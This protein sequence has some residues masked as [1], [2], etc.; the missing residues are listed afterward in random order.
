[1]RTSEIVYLSILAVY[2]CS[3][4]SSHLKDVLIRAEN[5]M[6]N[7]PDSALALLQSV[8]N[9]DKLSMADFAAYQLAYT[10]AKDKCY[11]DLA[12]DTANILKSLTYYSRC[13]D[14]KEKGW[15]NYYAGR[16]YQDAGRS[17]ESGLYFLK[18]AECGMNI[19]DYLLGMMAN[20]CLGELHGGQYAFDKALDSFK[21]AHRI[22][23]NVS[24]RRYESSLLN[25]IG[26]EYGI[27]DQLDSAFHYLYKAQEVACKQKDTLSMAAI[28]ND[29]AVYLRVDSQYQEAKFFLNQ[30]VLL[31]KDSNVMTIQKISMAEIYA[32]L[33]ESDSAYILLEEVKKEVEE[34]D[35][36]ELLAIYYYSLSKASFFDKNYELAFHYQEKYITC[37]DS[38]YQLQ[39]KNSL[40]E[41]EQMYNYVR[42]RDVNTS[43]RFEQRNTYVIL[44]ILLLI[45]F[46]V[47]LVAGWM[48]KRKKAALS[49][50]EEMIETLRRMQK[51]S[52][53]DQ[54][55]NTSTEK[56]IT[57]DS[58]DEAKEQ[59]IKRALLMQLNI[60]KVLAKLDEGSDKD[61]NFL[62]RFN[63]LF[64]GEQHIAQVDWDELYQLI[65]LLFDAFASKLQTHYASVLS[66]KEIQ[67]C[68]L[69][70][71][72][73]DTTEIACVMG[74]SINTVRTR[75]TTIRKK[76]SAP[77][78]C[79]I[80]DFLDISG[81]S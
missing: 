52:Q 56:P 12:A 70:R 73:M 78:A 32:Y 81:N 69:L 66:E 57:S 53:S 41:I 64:Y 79:N 22:Y 60:V 43:L 74:Q 38:V 46:L 35:D 76:L 67:L 27:M 55:N 20:Y 40:A 29:L 63:N 37:V 3:C 45:L 11:M 14:D 75:K 16:V 59:M 18:A 36:I 58:P 50:A 44:A 54:D 8:R 13:G 1:M 34:S 80:V 24:E 62:E 31:E 68:C 72:N 47:I 71:A 9:Q 28:Y 25:E 49:N 39:R 61:K 5:A 2:L 30:A 33:H 4:S 26:A 6:S 15:A 77:D 51:E 23:C 42:Y 7:N 65:N 21:A 17:L 48:I 10:K 19:P